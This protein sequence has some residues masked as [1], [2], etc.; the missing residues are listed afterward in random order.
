MLLREQA[1]AREREAPRVE[2]EKDREG[3]KKNKYIM[4]NKEY[5]DVY[6]IRAVLKGYIRIRMYVRAS[7]F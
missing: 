1:S 5:L 2:V 7:F 3:D 4:K 6:S